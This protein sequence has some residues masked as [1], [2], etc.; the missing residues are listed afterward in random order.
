MDEKQLSVGNGESLDIAEEM[1]ARDGLR[2]IYGTTDDSAP[3]PYGD[4][5]RKFSQIINTIFEKYSN[6]K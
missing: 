4:K 5:A 1:A 6:K 3:L 2:R